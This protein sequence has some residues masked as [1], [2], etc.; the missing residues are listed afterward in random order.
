VT[1]LF[2]LSWSLNIMSSVF[3]YEEQVKAFI[4][5]VGTLGVGAVKATYVGC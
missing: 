1:E 4:G 2:G 5:S 3:L